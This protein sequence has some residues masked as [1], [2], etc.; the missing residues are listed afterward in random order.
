MKKEEFL[1]MVTDEIETIKVRATDEEKEKLNFGVF[2]HKDSRCCIYGQMTGYCSSERAEELMPK[3]FMKISNSSGRYAIFNED[4][5][6]GDRY[7]A[8]E[9]YLFMVREKTHKA[10][11]DYLKGNVKELILDTKI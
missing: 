10:I 7:T 4:M 3:S 5:M 9:K 8:L 2:D 6:S 1:K 11:I